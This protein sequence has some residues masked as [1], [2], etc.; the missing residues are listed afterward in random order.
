MKE[1]LHRLIIIVL[2]VIFLISGAMVF[3][4]W[5]ADRKAKEEYARL[6]RMAGR[7][8]ESTAEAVTVETEPAET[9]PARKPYVPPI[10]FGVLQKENPDTA[11]WIK[12]E[13][14]QINYPVVQGTD[15]NFY[16][17]HDF[18]GKKSASGAIYLDFESQGDFDGRNNILYGHNMKNG[19]MFKDLVQY[20]DEA[21]FKEHQYFTIYTPEREIRLKAVAAYYGE[22]KPIVRKT[23]FISQESFDA[24][25]QAML[26]PCKYAE[27][28]RYPA[29]TLYTLVT[30]SYE[31]K[32]ARTFL[33]AVE[34]DGDG[35]EIPPD[36][37]F[38]QRMVD[39]CR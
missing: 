8:E 11:G 34:V 6:A 35:N 3:G 32:D 25:V 15:N 27:D 30:C 29:R 24:F 17:N 37:E 26:S 31:I 2:A 13:G 12:I 33:F 5:Q 20:K 39:N 38:Q 16:L 14:T 21:F 1:K 7:T 19:T 23:R 4:Q 22:A 9:E 18:N 10:D 36:G 28:V